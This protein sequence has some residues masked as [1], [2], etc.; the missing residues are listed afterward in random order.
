M[1][2]W[3]KDFTARC[4]LKIA[5][6]FE[7]PG[8]IRYIFGGGFYLLWWIWGTMAFIVFGVT[9]YIPISAIIFLV[10]LITNKILDK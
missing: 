2:E 4:F 3:Y 9:L 6:L 10:T 5:N 7:K 8:L 1:W